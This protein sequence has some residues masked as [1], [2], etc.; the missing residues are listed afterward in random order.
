MSVQVGWSPLLH[1]FRQTFSA[2]VARIQLK[3]RLDILFKVSCCSLLPAPFTVFRNCTQRLK[4][5]SPGDK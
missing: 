3:K 5:I 2:I 1:D 4:D